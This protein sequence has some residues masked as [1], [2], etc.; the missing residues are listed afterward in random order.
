[1]GVRWAMNGIVH[2]CLHSAVFID[3]LLYAKLEAKEIKASCPALI[4]LKTVNIH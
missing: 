4:V 2:V 1:M 3:H